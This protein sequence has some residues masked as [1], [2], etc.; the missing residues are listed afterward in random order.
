MAMWTKG[1][2][3]NSVKPPVSRC[4]ARVRTMWRAQRPG[5]LDGAEHDGDVG[6]QPDGVGRAVG[7]EPLLGVDLV[8][9]QHG[10]DLVVEDLGR[11]ARQGGAA[12]RPSAG[13]GSRPGARPRRLAPSVTSRAV[14]AWMWIRSV[15]ARTAL[16][17]S[18]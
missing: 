9:A 15:A 5:L 16:M 17:T 4:R 10:P 7:L 14:K 1:R 6:A 18:R 8:G 2:G 13:A 12:R 11:R 3:T